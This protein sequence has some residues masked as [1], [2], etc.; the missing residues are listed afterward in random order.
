MST[1]AHTSTIP[2]VQILLESS[3]CPRNGGRRNAGRGL[4]PRPHA[5]GC[6]HRTQQTWAAP[7]GSSPALARTCRRP[8]S[9]RPRTGPLRVAAPRTGDE[10]TATG[11]APT[12]ETRNCPTKKRL[13]A[14]RV[15]VPRQRKHL[16]RNRA[17]RI[18]SVGKDRQKG[19]KEN[20][21]RV[22]RQRLES[23][24]RIRIIHNK[25]SF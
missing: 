4:G 6:P 15:A 16:P 13:S 25:T 20:R 23:S 24:V 19:V 14:A 17:P 7:R 3:P 9:A 1:S 2:L 21:L 22:S 18:G 10:T 12:K 5:R 8:P 11:R